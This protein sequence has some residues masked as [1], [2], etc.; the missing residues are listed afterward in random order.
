MLDD[1]DEVEKEIV[2][3]LRQSEELGFSE[4]VESVKKRLAC[5]SPKISRRLRR[6][7]GLGLVQRQVTDDWPPGTAYSIAGVAEKTMTKGRR[8]QAPRKPLVPLRCEVTEEPSWLAG[9]LKLEIDRLLGT[10]NNV[11][12]GESFTVRGR[13]T[14][15]PDEAEPQRK[16]GK[17]ARRALEALGG[18]E[19]GNPAAII[20][21][22]RCA[23]GRGSGFQLYP[24]SRPFVATTQVRGAVR[25]DGKALG[26]DLYDVRNQQKATMVKELRLR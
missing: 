18:H 17:E 14:F 9:V 22:G 7:I 12:D 5:S 11:R 2:H 19:T 4:I 13:Y 16:G 6:L 15:R 10:S 20:F 25:G 24:G 8:T 21:E 1:L 3:V 23:R 26:L